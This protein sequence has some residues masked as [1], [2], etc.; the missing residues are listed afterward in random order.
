VFLAKIK[1]Y[2]DGEKFPL[3]IKIRDPSGNSNIKNPFA[4]RIDKNMQ[5]THFERTVEELVQMGY[6]KE[7]AEAEQGSIE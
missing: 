1:Q 3:T 6:N 4:P 2:I 7:N 5:I